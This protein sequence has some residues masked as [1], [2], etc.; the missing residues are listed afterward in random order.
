MVDMLEDLPAI[1]PRKP[2]RR[3]VLSMK[4]AADIPG[5]GLRFIGLDG[6]SFQPVQLKRHY[7]V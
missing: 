3:M 5:L 2:D 6:R 7:D 1:E 4:L